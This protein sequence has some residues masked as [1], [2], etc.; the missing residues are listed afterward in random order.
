MWWCPVTWP[1]PQCG[2]MFSWTIRT[3]KLRD[4]TGSR[5][6][7]Q[8]GG[9]H[10]VS[11]VFT[12]TDRCLSQLWRWPF[13]RTTSAPPTPPSLWPNYEFTLS[14]QKPAKSRTGFI[15]TGLNWSHRFNITDKYR[16][17]RRGF[18]M[19]SRLKSPDRWSVKAAVWLTLCVFVL[20][21]W[22]GSAV[23]STLD[24]YFFI[25]CFHPNATTSRGRASL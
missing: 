10:E 19:T 16:L 21:V 7:E 24:F 22:Q 6:T 12:L 13:A 11:E 15:L 4:K 8:I 20:C 25:H 17:R 2:C 3:H 9:P 1:P 23:L 18:M 5:K 14:P